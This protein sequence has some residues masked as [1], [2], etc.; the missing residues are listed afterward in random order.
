MQAPGLPQAGGP[1]DASVV[2]H[3]RIPYVGN[4]AVDAPA[5]SGWLL[6][7]LNAAGDVRHSDDVEIITFPFPVRAAAGRAATRPGSA[8]RYCSLLRHRDPRP[9]AQ[10]AV[11]G[12]IRRVKSA[13]GTVARK[14]GSGLST[15]R[16]IGR[17]G[18]TGRGSARR[19]GD[20]HAIPSRQ[21][22]PS[23]HCR[24]G[25]ERRFSTSPA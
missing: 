24:P 5:D 13:L 9:G 4:A 21:Q 15:S 7:Y 16:S 1:G 3:D 12:D 14:R 25:Q 22:D 20:F 10:P 17:G 23:S 6:G 18:R 8:G 11:T 19:G 2:A